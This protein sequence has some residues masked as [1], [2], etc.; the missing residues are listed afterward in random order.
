MYLTA[1]INRTQSVKPYNRSI[2]I[3]PRP[4]TTTNGN[5]RIKLPHR[6]PTLIQPH[7]TR[8]SI[9]HA[10]ICMRVKLFFNNNPFFP[11]RTSN[12]KNIRCES[13]KG[14]CEFVFVCFLVCDFNNTNNMHTFKFFP[15]VYQYI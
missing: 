1:S 9:D 2:S 13:H 10:V 15:S 14:M 11:S 6:Q 5:N 3:S 7:I 8:F 4:S 12:P